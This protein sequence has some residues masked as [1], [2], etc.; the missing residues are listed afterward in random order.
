MTKWN[1]DL[2]AIEKKEEERFKAYLKSFDK[3]FADMTVRL[4]AITI[5]HLLREA[6]RKGIK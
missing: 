1:R 4:E 6:Q 5:S 3:S 2:P